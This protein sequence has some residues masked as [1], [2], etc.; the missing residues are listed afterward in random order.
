MDSK[1]L[2]PDRPQ[3]EKEIFIQKMIDQYQKEKKEVKGI[4][5]M[6]ELENKW[7]DKFHEVTVHDYNQYKE[8]RN[9]GFNPKPMSHV[10]KGTYLHESIEEYLKE[11]PKRIPV[12]PEINF[13]INPNQT[14]EAQRFLND[15]VI[16]Q[17]RRNKR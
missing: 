17:K 10:W 13:Y 11:A 2:F 9:L 6:I 4:F 1:E 7:S 5:G 15:F 12:Y 3:K 16:V 14:E 8:L